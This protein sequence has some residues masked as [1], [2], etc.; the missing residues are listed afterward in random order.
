MFAPAMNVAEDP[1]TG[2]APEPA[3]AHGGESRRRR[4]VG[5]GGRGG[6]GR[7]CASERE[8]CGSSGP[9]APMPRLATR[10]GAS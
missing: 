5:A 8:C 2:E 9:P 6:A 10:A 1:A 7:R 4:T 3:R